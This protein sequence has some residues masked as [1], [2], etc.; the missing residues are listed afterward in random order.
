MGTDYDFI[1]LFN[2]VLHNV[3]WCIELLGC[4]SFYNSYSQGTWVHIGL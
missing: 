4:T 1:F 2:L 3:H